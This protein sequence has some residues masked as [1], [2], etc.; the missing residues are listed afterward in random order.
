MLAVG[1]T[2]EALGEQTLMAWWE[3]LKL[4]TVAQWISVALLLAGIVMV[5]IAAATWEYLALDC[6]LQSFLVLELLLR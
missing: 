4:T 6:R 5:A 2:V 3:K 1:I